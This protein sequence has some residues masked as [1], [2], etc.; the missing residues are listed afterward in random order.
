MLGWTTAGWAGHRHVSSH[1]HIW[2]LCTMFTAYPF[3]AF[4]KLYYLNSCTT[5]SAQ[6]INTYVT[7]CTW[8]MRS[9]AAKTSTHVARRVRND[10]YESSGAYYQERY[11]YHGP[12]P[13]GHHL[14]NRHKQQTA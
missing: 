7:S 5:K 6:Q 4:Q 10:T 3:A 14:R 9:V 8:T 12:P 11:R 2:N 13:P 1:G